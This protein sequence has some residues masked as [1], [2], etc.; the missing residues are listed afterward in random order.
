[1]ITAAERG[2]VKEA[3]KK[4]LKYEIGIHENISR[5]LFKEKVIRLMIEEKE[6][7]KDEMFRELTADK[8][9]NIV[10]IR[11]LKSAHRKWNR[12]FKFEVRKDAQKR[13]R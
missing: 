3:K 7:R 2:V 1:L 10:P 9:G 12:Q 5:G 11:K 4:R 13:P 8:E 6:N